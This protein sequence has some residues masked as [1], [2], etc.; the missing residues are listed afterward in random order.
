MS[1]FADGPG[2]FYANRKRLYPGKRSSL[3]TIAHS[4]G[5]VALQHPNLPLWKG[6]F[7]SPGGKFRQQFDTDFGAY[8]QAAKLRILDPETELQV[9][10]VVGEL[11]DMRGRRRILEHA[12]MTARHVHQ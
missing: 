1:S 3:R 5:T 11:Q 6:N 9:H 4:L 8:V 7:D 2:G 10:A 12:W